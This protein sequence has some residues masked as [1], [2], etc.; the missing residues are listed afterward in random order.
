MYI[1]PPIGQ[2]RYYPSV[3]SLNTYFV[4]MLEK[5]AVELP[6][7]KRISFSL[8]DK[9][10]D[11][12]KTYAD[13]S[14]VSH[15]FVHYEF[16]LADLPSLQQIKQTQ[17]VRII[18]D[19]PQQLHS[20]TRHNDWLLERQYRSSFTKPIFHQQAFIG[21]L[22]FNSSKEYYFT[23]QVIER[24]QAYIDLLQQAVCCEYALVHYLIKNVEQMKS[25]SPDHWQYIKQHKERIRRYVRIIALDIA[26]QYALDDGLIENISQFATCHDLGKLALPA[27]LL[28]KNPSLASSERLQIYRHIEHGIELLN[29][30]IEKLGT[31]HHPCLAV[32]REIMAYHHEFLDGS[33]YPFGLT[34]E[35]IP[36]PAR[37]V[38]VA[39]IFDALTAHRPYQQAQSITHTLLELEKMVSEGKLDR[40]CVNALRENQEELKAIVGRFPD[41]D[42]KDG[43]ATTDMDTAPSSTPNATLL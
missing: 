19:M 22:F 20:Q 39:N 5:I 29:N 26:E 3:G 25:N 36:I 38:A 4:N 17:T 24:L 10:K 28:Q 37:I 6:D 14:L 35:Q 2:L 8:Y 34:R 21:F 27:D 7:I 32:L 40:D 11:S 33:G 9:K 18:D 43:E 15:D 41:L 23:P 1:Q 31:P 16:A 30:V 12:I 42:P 13:S